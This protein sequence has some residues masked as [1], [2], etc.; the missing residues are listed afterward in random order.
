MSRSWD[1]EKIS[2]LVSSGGKDGLALYGAYWRVLEI[3]AEQ[4]KKGSENYSVKYSIGKWSHLMSVR[5]SHVRHYIGQLVCHKLLKAEWTDTELLVTV[6][7]LLKIRDE[8]SQRSGESHDQELDTDTDTDT[9]KEKTPPTPSC[10]GPVPESKKPKPQTAMQR[11]F[12]A[13][14]E[15]VWLKTGPAA[16]FKAY[17][18]QIKSGVSSETILDAVRIQSPFLKAKGQY[19]PHP[20]TWLNQARFLDEPAAYQ[21]RASPN[22]H[23]GSDR[24]AAATEQFRQ[25]LFR[26]MEEKNAG[27]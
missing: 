7:N 5:G 15:I 11:D 24:K 27:A 18:K 17:E 16:A 13:I 12:Q 23:Y 2:A 6:P 3:V 1:D 14:W 8:Y 26:E 4:M 19:A 9:K 25:R 21:A 22:G 20:A 10:E